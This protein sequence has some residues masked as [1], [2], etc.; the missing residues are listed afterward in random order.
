MLF[1]STLTSIATSTGGGS[2]QRVEVKVTAPETA[3]FPCGTSRRF[4]NTLK[5]KCKVARYFCS[6]NR[7]SILKMQVTYEFTVLL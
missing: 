1:A 7:N 6:L 5:N 4:T 3:C 2:Y